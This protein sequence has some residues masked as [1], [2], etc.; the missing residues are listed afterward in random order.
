MRARRTEQ[1]RARVTAWVHGTATPA[2]EGSR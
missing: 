1:I 2:G